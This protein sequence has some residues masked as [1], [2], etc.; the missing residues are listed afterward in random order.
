MI[1]IVPVVI[2]VVVYVILP[3]QT[4]LALILASLVKTGPAVVATIVMV[5]LGLL[6]FAAPALILVRLQMLWL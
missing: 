3:L 4:V 1:V 5:R 6:D 2:L